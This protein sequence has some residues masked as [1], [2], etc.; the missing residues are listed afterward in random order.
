MGLMESGPKLVIV[1]LTAWSQPIAAIE[2]LRKTLKDVRVV[3]FRSHVQRELAAQ[4]Q[5]AGCDEVLPRSSCTQNVAAIV[6]AAK[7]GSEITQVEVPR[8]SPFP[9]LRRSAHSREHPLAGI[10]LHARW[11]FRERAERNYNYGRTQRRTESRAF[12]GLFP[13]SNRVCAFSHGSK[14]GGVFPHDAAR[15]RRVD[16]ALRASE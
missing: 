15:T 1:A 2:K 10:Q 9:E 14:Q 6:S 5:A 7:D 3:G 11:K 4:A 13:E 12:R 16:E 8:T